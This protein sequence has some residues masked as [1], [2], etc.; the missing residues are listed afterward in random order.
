MEKTG[1][2]GGGWVVPSKSLV[3]ILAQSQSFRWPTLLIRYGKTEL[4][5]ETSGQVALKLGRWLHANQRPTSEDIL[6]NP[7]STPYT[8]EVNNIMTPASTVLKR[9][10]LDPENTGKHWIPAKKWLQEQ[11]APLHDMMI[12]YACTL[13]LIERAMIANWFEEKICNG[14][15]KMRRHWLGLLPIAHAHDTL[16]GEQINTRAEYLDEAWLLL[17]NQRKDVQIAQ[18]DSLLDVDIDKECLEQLEKLM[19]ERSAR[20]GA[21]GHYQWGL[22]AGSHQDGWDP[23][24]GLPP[25]WYHN[26]REEQEGELEFHKYLKLLSSPPPNG[27]DH[28]HVSVQK[29][30]EEVTKLKLKLKHRERLGVCVRMGPRTHI[31]RLSLHK[32]SYAFEVVYEE[33]SIEDG[34]FEPT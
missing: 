8:K 19:F 20:A 30:K 12:P 7:S 34:R 3:L 28:S 2:C 5:G 14:D 33:S 32:K 26:D 18:K 22:D 25:E 21:A 17:L 27:H 15:Q 10:L 11:K 31:R 13:S 24:A 29:G 23:Y 6:S 9:L 16:K 1:V 4:E